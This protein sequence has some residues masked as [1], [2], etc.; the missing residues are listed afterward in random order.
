MGDILP[1]L[2]SI[3]CRIQLIASMRAEPEVHLGLEENVSLHS[4]YASY[5][6]F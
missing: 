5:P 4:A 6:R 3:Q 2:T 1:K